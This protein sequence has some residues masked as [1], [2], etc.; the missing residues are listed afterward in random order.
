MES[1]NLEN[2]FNNHKDKTINEVYLKELPQMILYS[3]RSLNYFK[4]DFCFVLCTILSVCTIL[5]KTG[6]PRK[7]KDFLIMTVEILINLF[8]T[9][10][11]SQHKK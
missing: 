8:I 10:K 11:E 3:K 9:V 4:V 1:I 5:S 7:W 6:F 2:S